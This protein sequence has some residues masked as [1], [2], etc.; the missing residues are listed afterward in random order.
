M[1]PA[2][3]SVYLDPGCPT[4]LRGIPQKFIGH[5]PK[6]EGHPGFRYWP[7]PSRLVHFLH[8]VVLHWASALRCDCGAEVAGTVFF[9]VT[10]SELEALGQPISAAKAGTG[11]GCSRRS[12]ASGK[13][14]QRDLL[15]TP[16]AW[17]WALVR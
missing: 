13:G 9:Q 5:N 16:E 17:L 3:S 6:K 7:V 15:K 1:S 10:N 12:N 2:S 11:A 14:W 8:I 4:F